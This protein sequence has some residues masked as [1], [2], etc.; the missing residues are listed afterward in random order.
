M[1][2]HQY[3]YPT[4]IELRRAGLQTDGHGVRAPSAGPL[5][6]RRLGHPSEHEHIGDQASARPAS[7]AASAGTPWAA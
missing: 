3:T 1:G 7:T 2:Q 6:A 4:V 5:G